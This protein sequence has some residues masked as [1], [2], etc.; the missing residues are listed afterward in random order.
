MISIKGEKSMFWGIVFVVIGAV[1]L[2]NIGFGFN[3][4]V[5]R[6]LFGVLLIYWGIKVIIGP[7]IKNYSFEFHSEESVVFDSA[8]FKPKKGEM[9][10]PEYNI[11]FSEGVVDLSEAQFNGN[12]QRIEVNTIFGHAKI[13]VP[14][15]VLLEP[16]INSVAASV[17][18]P[19]EVEVTPNS[20]VLKLVL[21]T[22]F[23]AAEVDRAVSTKK[24]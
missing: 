10:K 6:T 15:N 1:I 11:I 13:I 3:L 23:G 17:K 9:F 18:L 12:N 16:K 22:I 4:P 5:M 24:E 20:P 8:K 2:L 14:A 7:S 19:Q 21:N